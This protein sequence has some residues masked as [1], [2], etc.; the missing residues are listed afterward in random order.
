MDAIMIFDCDNY[1]IF[2]ESNQKFLE[3]I[4]LYAYQNKLIQT[5]LGNKIKKTLANNS[6]ELENIIVL[7]LAPLIAA[8][9]VLGNC[10]PP[11]DIFQSS[12]NNV[13]ILHT[14]VNVMC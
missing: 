10:C 2:S 9:R 11:I 14:Q 7:I 6:K 12:P 13:R 5:K 4:A 8:I 1:L 3:E